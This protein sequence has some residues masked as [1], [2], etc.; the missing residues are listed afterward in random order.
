MGGYGHKPCHVPEYPVSVS[1]APGW[2]AVYFSDEP[3]GWSAVP[4]VGWAV[5]QIQPGGEGP[6]GCR[7]CGTYTEIHGLIR[8]YDEIDAAICED[9]FWYYLAPGEPEPTPE[10]AASISS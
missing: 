5:F 4:L 10:V 9:E 2:R 6:L 7:T 8:S 3:P 1:A